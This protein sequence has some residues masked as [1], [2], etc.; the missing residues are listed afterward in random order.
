MSLAALASALGACAVPNVNGVT[1]TSPSSGPQTLIGAHGPLSAARSREILDAL[2]HQSPDSDILDRHLAI[3]QAVTGVPLIAGNRTTILHDGGETFAAMFDAIRNAQAA[4]NL[5]FYTFEDVE[6]GGEH[7]GALLVAKRAQGVAVNI[8]YDSYG[9]MD[10]PP[11]FLK[12]LRAAG[13]LVL[14]YNPIDPLHARGAYRPNDRDHR[15]ILIV[16]GLTA[17]VGGVNLYTGYQG[18]PHSELVGSGGDTSVFWH[19]TDLEIEGPAV[20]ALQQLFVQ[21]WIDQGGPPLDQST[22]FPPLRRQGSEVLHVLGSTPSQPVPA[23]YATILSAITNAEQRIWLTTAYFVPTDD[24]LDDL[25]SAARRGV[26]VRLMLPSQSDSPSAFDVGRSY[27]DDLLEAGVKIYEIQNEV[28]HSK[29][30]AIDGVWSVIGSSNFDHRSVLFNDEVDVV[31]LGR[32]TATQ[33]EAE[34]QADEAKSR[35]ID[36]TTWSHRPFGER[37]RE[38]FTRLWQSM[39]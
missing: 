2:K 36:A 37:I 25:E 1:A 35:T 26:D 17:F 30:A 8:L 18:H 7:L 4:V 13:C 22:F 9:S 29:T 24:E 38:L 33:L 23:Y 34:F 12:S 16:D 21:H 20:V 14:Q 15:K 28:L 27:Y 10:T 19:D 31:V 6:S 39:L 5:E 11:E 3:E 32:A